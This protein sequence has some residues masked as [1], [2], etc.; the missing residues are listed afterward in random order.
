MI[1]PKLKEN[2]P[3]RK[4]QLNRNLKKYIEVNLE[5][6]RTNPHARVR[7]DIEEELIQKYQ[8]NLLKKN[9]DYETSEFN[10]YTKLVKHKKNC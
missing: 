8:L 3:F 4:E 1:F 7:T 5:D 9:S 6:E 2:Y 10:H